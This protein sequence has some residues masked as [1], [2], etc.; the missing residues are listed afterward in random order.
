[1]TA[2]FPKKAVAALTLAAV[3]WHGAWATTIPQ[4]IDW[5][6]AYYL[7]VA[8]NLAHGH[9]AVTH[10]IWHLS[11]PDLPLPQPA[12]LHWMPLPSRILVPL[13]WLLGTVGASVTAVLVAAAWVPVTALLAH[14]LSPERRVVVGASLLAV[15]GGGYVRFLSTPDSMGL[16][17]LLGGLAWWTAAR[18]RTAPTLLLAA[19]LALTRGDGFLLAPC[20]G[21]VLFLHGSR[22]GAV[23]VSAAG[24]VAFA[25]WS[26]RSWWLAGPELLVARAHTSGAM[27]IHDLL[28]GRTPDPSL[29]ERLNALYD[30]VSGAIGA[31]LLVGVV[32]LPILAMWGA[33]RDRH[34]PLVRGI[35]VYAPGFVLVTHLLAPGVA[36]SGT[37]FRSGAALFLPACALAT[38]AAFQLGDLGHRARGYPRWL[39]PGLLALGFGVGT[40]GLGLG[41]KQARPGPPITCLDAPSTG[42]VLSG[43][44]LLVRT[45]CGPPAL[46]L[47]RGEDPTAVAQR[48]Q[49]HGAYVAWL[50][51]HDTDPL[52]PTR[53]DAPILLP[54]WREWAP[55]LFL[56]PDAPSPTVPPKGW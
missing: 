24:P 25:T 5:D 2:P 51:E 37:A 12:D 26:V 30:G 16:F 29:T 28:L 55:G 22:T 10:A 53:S 42:P 41:T 3:A 8:T 43:R 19:L 54:G 50:P 4:P 38:I 31:A 47:F 20:L 40:V 34:N 6:P 33:A 23:A 45:I 48:A 14:H 1:M 35:L 36:A 17:G 18:N 11:G 52:V 32:F 21:L 44:P 13:V 27:H 56:H 15:L 7:D 46:A 39:V 9:G 49:R